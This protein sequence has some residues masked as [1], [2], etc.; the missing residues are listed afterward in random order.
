MGIPVAGTA[1]TRWTD[2]EVD[3][4]KQ[5]PAADFEAVDESCLMV[6][7]DSG[8]AYQPGTIGYSESCG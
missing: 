3:Q 5:I 1:D 4:L 7:G 8:Q 2:A 6:S